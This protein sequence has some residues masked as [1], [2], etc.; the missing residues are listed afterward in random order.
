MTDPVMIPYGKTGSGYAGSATSR[1]RQERED[2][3]GK[4]A[5]RQREA[6]QA[7]T[8]A[9]RDGMT[10]SEIEERYGWHHGQS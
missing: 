4:T 6:L 7:I 10:V 5:Y 8:Q 3:L 1:E 9:G 2:G